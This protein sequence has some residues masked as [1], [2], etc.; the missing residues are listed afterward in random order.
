MELPSTR[1]KSI[2]LS[3]PK[4]SIFHFKNRFRRKK[5]LSYITHMTRTSWQ[6][7]GKSIR[8]I[9]HVKKMSNVFPLISVPGIT[10]NMYSLKEKIPQYLFTGKY[11]LPSR[12]LPENKHPLGVFLSWQ[13]STLLENKYALKFLVNRKE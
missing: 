9:R 2:V 5:F 7:H 11:L 1:K 10:V 6:M 8:H 4:L 3:D 13:I 12:S